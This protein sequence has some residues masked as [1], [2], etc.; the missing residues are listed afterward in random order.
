MQLQF[1]YR[2]KVKLLYKYLYKHS[3]QNR[4]LVT[5]KT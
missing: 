3:D 1:L 5:G 4:Y 2:Q